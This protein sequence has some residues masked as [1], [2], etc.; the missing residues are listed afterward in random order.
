MEELG[1]WGHRFGELQFHTQ[2]LEDLQVERQSKAV[3][4]NLSRSIKR[5]LM[6]FTCFQDLG[7]KNIY[8]YIN[9]GYE[10]IARPQDSKLFH[11]DEIVSF[12]LK[13]GLSLWTL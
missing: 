12:G 4:V 5:Y 13:S 6:C 11:T 1:S 2:A 10:N 3:S 9:K 8:T 7:L